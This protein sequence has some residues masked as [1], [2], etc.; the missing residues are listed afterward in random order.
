MNW[1]PSSL[2]PPCPAVWVTAEKPTFLSPGISW[3]SSGSTRPLRPL[4]RKY[5]RKHPGDKGITRAAYVPRGW[6]PLVSHIPQ[7][8]SI[9]W[10]IGNCVL[11]G[12]SGHLPMHPH[13]AQQGTEV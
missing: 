9:N 6:W 7:E 3:P 12:P 10:S 5:S 11:N 4:E 13:T 1:D 2:I 8:L